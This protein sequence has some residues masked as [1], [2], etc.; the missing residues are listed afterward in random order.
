MAL[1]WYATFPDPGGYD[2]P[3]L[4]LSH[5]RRGEILERRGDRETA[6]HHYERVLV[7]WANAE[8]QMQTH[9]GTLRARMEA[10]R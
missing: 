9:V 6:R 3:W 4:T 10:S 7:L 2:L 1:R 8:P 5:L